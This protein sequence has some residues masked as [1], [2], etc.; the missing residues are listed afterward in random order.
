MF[1]KRAHVHLPTLVDFV[2][3]ADSGQNVESKILSL[4]AAHVRVTVDPTQAEPARK[5]GN[6]PPRRPHKI[7]TAAEVNAEV[8][9]FHAAKDRLGDERET[10]LIVAASPIVAVVYAPANTPG[11]KFRTDLVTVGVAENAEQVA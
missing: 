7:V 1:V 2:R 4:G 11:H 9:I 8:M 6:Q 10:K 3:N 5:V